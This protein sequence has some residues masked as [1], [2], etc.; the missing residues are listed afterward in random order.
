M[1][2]RNGLFGCCVAAALATLAAAAG[3]A[4]AQSFTVQTLHFQVHVGPQGAQTCN[5][6]GDLY[7]PADATASHPDPAIL[8]TNG[9]GGTKNDQR[10]EAQTFAQHGYVVLSYSGLGFGGSGCQ[11]ELDAPDWDGA[12][13]SQ[14]ITFLGGGSAST[15][16]T[17]VDYVTHDQVDHL[18]QH[19]AYDPRVGMI[20][21]SYGGQVQFSAAAQDPRIDAI[22]RSSPGTTFPTRWRRTTPR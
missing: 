13:A 11:I 1:A 19:A 8:T 4:A 21:G 15:N 9:L 16:G 3:P 18:G 17:R 20:G 2:A 10:P 7:R 5:I 6:V 22:V 12:A 14:L